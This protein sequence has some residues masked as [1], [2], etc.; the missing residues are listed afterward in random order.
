MNDIFAQ[1]L[2]S[3]RLIKGLSMEELANA[4]GVS[5]QMISKYEAA[6]SMPDSSVLIALSRALEQKAD[7]FF[8]PRKIQIGEVEFRKKSSLSSKTSNGIAEQVHVMLENYIAVEDILSIESK[9]ENP[10]ERFVIQNL[11]DVEIAVNE[12]RSKWEIGYDPI[13]NIV[14]LLEYNEI[15]VLEIDLN[16]SGFDGMATR[17]DELYPVVVVN[18]NFPIERKRFTLLHELGHLLLKFT[19]DFTHKEIEQFC[20]RFAA[21]LLLPAKVA[22]EK[23]GEHRSQLAIKELELIQRRFGISIPAIV[24]R[25]AD[26]KVI[27]PTLL[28][29][30][31]IRMRSDEQ[32]KNQV[33][34]TRYMG[35]E[36]STR[37][38]GLIHRA[39]TQ[40]LMSLSR[41]ASLLGVSISEIRK[42]Y[43]LV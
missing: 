11:E 2:K 33:S 1:R 23:L 4:V 5:K 15:K 40:E 19:A 42:S 29:R 9:F 38:E 8:R 26:L 20:N 3:A 43:Q 34:V 30:F 17:V 16:M 22:I 6:K 25:L 28:R 39:L 21:A 12:L 27:T 18:K 32:F 31:F 24:Y 10:L 13:L 14:E 41:A 37:Y 7:Y 36:T 35:E